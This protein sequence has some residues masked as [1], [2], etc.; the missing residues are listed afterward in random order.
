MKPPFDRS[1]WVVPG[2]LLAGCYPGLSSPDKTRKKLQAL[3]DCG[4]RHTINLMNS[5]EIQY[6]SGS[7]DGYLSEMRSMGSVKGVNL[8]FTQMP[9]MDMWIPLHKD[10]A[11][12]LDHIDRAI[13]DGKPVYVHCWGGRGRTGTVVGCYLARHGYASGANV[14][15]MINDLRKDA[16]DSHLAS[17]ETNQQRAMVMGW[18][19]NLGEPS[20]KK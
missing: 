8:S 16:A 1:Y 12:I 7:A 18:A 14:L 9:I 20:W 2:K 10:M 15:E 5:D 13:Q 4:I 6:V 3:I 11:R 19:A 17:P